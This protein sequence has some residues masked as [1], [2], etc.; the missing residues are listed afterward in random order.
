MSERRYEI[1]EITVRS[2]LQ[3]FL[4]DIDARLNALETRQNADTCEDVSPIRPEDMS[5]ELANSSDTKTSEPAGKPSKSQETDH[6]FP[7]TRD[8]PVQENG[9]TCANN[10]TLPD[11]Q[12]DGLSAE[13]PPT[14][15]EPHTETEVEK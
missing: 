11:A 14:G 1:Y 10:P 7:E 6:D 5:S 15:D 9:A 3:G 4:D 8:F 12:A 13:S 2:A